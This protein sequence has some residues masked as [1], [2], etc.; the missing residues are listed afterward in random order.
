MT[1]SPTADTALFGQLAMRH[2]GYKSPERALFR[3]RQTFEHLDLA[4]KSLLEIGAGPGVF[5]AY[6][7]VMGAR[8]VAALEPEAAGSARG[9][10]A[11]I[12]LMQQGLG[13]ANFEVRSETIQDY[14]SQGRL[15]DLVLLYNSVNHLDEHACATLL[16]SEASKEAYRAVFGRVARLMTPGARLVIA[17]CSRHNFFPMLGLKN[18]LARSIEWH[19]HQTPCTWDELLRPLGFARERLTWYSYYPLRHF[20]RMLANRAASFFINSHF[21]LVLRYEGVARP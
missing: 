11:A 7:V 12:R 17:D 1:A 8:W 10:A 4:G 13:A 9:A 19:K 18:P 21:R 3:A 5:S 16:E 14:D 6:A 20:G 2:A 15:F